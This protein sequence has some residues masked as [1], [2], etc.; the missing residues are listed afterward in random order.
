[1]VSLTIA[2]P[3]PAQRP[4]PAVPPDLG[5]II[6][7]RSP[8]LFTVLCALY[9][10]GFESDVVFANSHPLHTRLR[11]EMAALKGPAVE[12]LREFYRTNR[13]SPD[14][15]VTLS[16]YV[17]F[18][19]VTGPPPKFEYQLTLEQL[20]PDVRTLDGL[21]PVLAQFY[22]EAG[23]ARR[24]QQLARDYEQ[25]IRRVQAPLSDI[26]FRTAGYLR[27]LID[28]GTPR[29][30]TVYVE[31]LVGAKTNLRNYGESYAVVLSPNRDLPLDD[32]R[33]GFLH[34]LL[35]P[36]PYRHRRAVERLRPLL[37]YANRAPRFPA[38]YREQFPAYVVECLVRAVELR[39]QQPAAGRLAEELQSA[40]A[41]GF[42][43]VRP[44]YERLKVFET[45]EPAMTFYLPDLLG[46]IHLGT[47]AARLEKVQFAPA[48]D[49]VRRIAE[50]VAQ[51]SETERLLNEAE[52]LIADR[53]AAEA[54]AAFREVLSKEPA[55]ARALYGA[56]IS[57]ALLRDVERAKRLFQ[58]V[59]TGAGVERRAS[60]ARWLAWSHVY[61]GR[62][63]DVEGKR[64]LALTEFRAA[65]AIENA[66]EN[67]RAAAQR[68]LEKGYRPSPPSERP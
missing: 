47:E 10:A 24:W 7:S 19:L 32:I 40:D 37:T 25:E 55:N 14:P 3:A 68:G 50:T 59:I 35:D 45:A 17:S 41:D 13:R 15:V 52:A 51:I 5:S 31:P 49:A 11:R 18:A 61:L 20:P 33:H 54:D 42:I 34:Y 16:R 29:Q 58:R 62:I 67:V 8:Q 2:A 12:A 30:F 44:L 9:A 56:G 60:D 63:Y 38:E 65:L 36:L 28:Q 46:G 66:P 64:D 23:I 39:M 21:T 48:R 1:M 57:A 26:V 27:E 22:A 53:K 6:T 4:A 43:F